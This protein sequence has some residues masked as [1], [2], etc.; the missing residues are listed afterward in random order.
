MPD[1]TCLT[2]FIPLTTGRAFGLCPVG[3]KEIILTNECDKW[4]EVPEKINAT[5]AILLADREGVPLTRPT[6]IKY[7]TEHG[8]GYQL[9]GTQWGRWIIHTKKFIKFLDDGGVL[10]DG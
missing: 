1:R 4:Q 3:Q 5:E 6:I 7:C 9:G 10:N 2:C 8:I